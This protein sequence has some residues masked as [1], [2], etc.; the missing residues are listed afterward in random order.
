V[1]Q[2]A[3]ITAQQ[4]TGVCAAHMLCDLICGLLPNVPW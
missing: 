4:W 2:S 1:E 3:I